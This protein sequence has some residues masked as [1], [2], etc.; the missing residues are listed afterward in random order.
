MQRRHVLLVVERG[1]S[2]GHLVLGRNEWVGSGTADAMSEGEALT[3]TTGLAGAASTVASAGAGGTV[4][5]VQISMNVGRTIL[6]GW[7]LLGE[8]K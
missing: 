4:T 7:S 6:R 8:L 2:Y 5:V 1:V 3:Y